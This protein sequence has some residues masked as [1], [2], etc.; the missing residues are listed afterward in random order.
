M[1]QCR[2][3]QG[4]GVRSYA[5]TGLTSQ[6]LAKRL[7]KCGFPSKKRSSG[8]GID[9]K[10]KWKET[11]KKKEALLVESRNPVASTW[12]LVALCCGTHTTHI[13]YYLGI[14]IHGSMLDI[15][16]NSY[17]K[18]GLAVGALL[19]PR[20]DLLFDG[21]LAFTKGSPNMNSLVGFGAAFAISSVS[22]LNPELQWE[23]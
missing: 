2:I 18:A 13:L 4:C 20:R 7:L 21:L 12:T 22:L 23:A 9:A 19:G 15:L 11:V 16:H 17:D 5:E 8:L 6:E 3:G 14:H 10:V 1:A